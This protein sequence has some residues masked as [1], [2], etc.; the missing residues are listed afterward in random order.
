MSPDCGTQNKPV[1]APAREIER[2]LGPRDV[3]H[4]R[5]RVAR[6]CHEQRCNARRPAP[7]AASKPNATSG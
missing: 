4:H 6:Q 1:D 7:M 3:G 2:L 5:G